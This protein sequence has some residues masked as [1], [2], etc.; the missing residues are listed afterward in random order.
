[1]KGF[2]TSVF[3]DIV[4]SILLILIAKFTPEAMSG[5]SILLGILFVFSLFWILYCIN[6]ADDF[7]FNKLMHDGIVKLSKK[8]AFWRVY[9]IITDIGYMIVFIAYF[10]I[11]FLSILLFLIICSKFFAYPSFDKYAKWY[12]TINLKGE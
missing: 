11:P 12:D 2:L 5:F 6:L 1:M 8:H 7:T 4:F 10:H 3:T 9:D